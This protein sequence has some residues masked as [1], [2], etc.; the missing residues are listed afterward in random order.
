MTESAYGTGKEYD[1]F[2][3]NQLEE[4]LTQYGDVFEVCLDGANGEGPNRKRQIYD[5]ERYNA[6]IRQWQPEGSH[7]HLWS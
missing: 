7:C 4:L 1:D 6:T 5:W 2:F 3:V